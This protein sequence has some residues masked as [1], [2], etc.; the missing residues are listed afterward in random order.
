MKVPSEPSPS[1]ASIALRD[2]DFVDIDE[3]LS[4][5][6]W[7]IVLYAVGETSEVW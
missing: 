4:S 3:W 5:C 7:N 2:Q 6:L 1:L